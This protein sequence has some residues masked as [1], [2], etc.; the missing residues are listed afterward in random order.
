VLYRAKWGVVP[1]KNVRALTGTEGGGG[2]A[3]VLPSFPARCGA[4]IS[5]RSDGKAR[6]L[7][8]EGAGCHRHNGAL[9]EDGRGESMHAVP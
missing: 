6:Q 9:G 5:N 1:V 3:I 2:L 8:K 7:V 4:S